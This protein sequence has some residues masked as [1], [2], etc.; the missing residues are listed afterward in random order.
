MFECE[1]RRTSGHSGKLNASGFFK[2]EVMGLTKTTLEKEREKERERERKK[3]RER[4]RKRERERERCHND[5]Q[6]H[7]KC[8]EKAGTYLDNNS[9]KRCHLV[10]NR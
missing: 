10:M 3:E 7:F 1:D 4:E 8:V 5:N 6:K 2:L 9:S